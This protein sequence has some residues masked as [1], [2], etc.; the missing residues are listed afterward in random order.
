MIH[1]V[2]CEHRRRVHLNP[3]R[4]QA[5]DQFIHRFPAG[6]GDR[7][8]YVHVRRPAGDLAGLALHFSFIIGKHFERNGTIGNLLQDFPGETLIVGDARF[9]H[10]GWIRSETLD[11]GLPVELKHAGLVGSVGKH[12]NPQFRHGL[13]LY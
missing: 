9:P 10:Q 11:V 6:I 2:E 3:F 7:N 5:P 12:L 4:A 1:L 13:H 8:F